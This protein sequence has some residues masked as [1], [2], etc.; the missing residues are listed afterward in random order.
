MRDAEL[1]VTDAFGDI[2]IVGDAPRQ[3]HPSSAST[4]APA[5]SAQ[6]CVFTFPVRSKHP[7]A[8]PPAHGPP[9]DPACPADGTAVIL[10]RHH[11]AAPGSTASAAQGPG[12]GG[13]GCDLQDGLG[14]PKGWLPQDDERHSRAFLRAAS[15]DTARPRDRD[16]R[17]VAAPQGPAQPEPEAEADPAGAQVPVARVFSAA[18]QAS[19][20]GGGGS[21]SRSAG[22]AGSAGGAPP[23][24]PCSGSGSGSA[25][26]G[27]VHAEWWK[28]FSSSRLNE[29]AAEEPD[30]RSPEMRHVPY[31]SVHGTAAAPTV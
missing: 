8:P 14:L 29:M 23:G 1:I 18:A 27:R 24:C 4:A 20:N 30:P 26:A 31:T 25:S 19:L 10:I 22:G 12:P 15:L 11:K 28:S 3:R 5:C 17:P 9:L 13:A 2:F 7:V 16:Q 21:F 6:P